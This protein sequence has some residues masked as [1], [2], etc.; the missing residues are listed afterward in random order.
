MNLRGFREGIRIGAVESMPSEDKITNF[1]IGKNL[2][3]KAKFDTFGGYRVPTVRPEVSIFAEQTAQ[4][5]ERTPFKKVGNN[6]YRYKSLSLQ[7]AKFT[8]RSGRLFPRIKYGSGSVY[9]FQMQK[10][11]YRLPGDIDE[12]ALISEMGLLNTLQEVRVAKFN[13]YSKF[14][15]A[16][17]RSRRVGL[18]IEGMNPRRN[19]IDLHAQGFGSSEAAPETFMGRSLWGETRRI[20]GEVYTILA[21]EGLRKS[22][23][24]FT[25]RRGDT[26]KIVFSPEAHRFKDVA[27]MWRYAEQARRNKGLSKEFGEGWREEFSKHFGEWKQYEKAPESKSSLQSSPAFRSP[28]LRMSFAHLNSFSMSPSRSASMSRSLSRRLSMSMSASM[29]R[30]M[31]RSLRPSLSPSRSPSPSR[32]FSR[33]MSRSMSRSLRPSL[34]PSRSP[35]PSRS[36]SLYMREET[37]REPPF[38]Y[39]IAGALFPGWSMEGYR[40]SRRKYSYAPELTSLEFGITSKKAP[41]TPKGGWSGLEIRPLVI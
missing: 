28:S 9:Q 24:V 15:L 11:I 21:E 4:L 40:P 38:S 8:G 39:V 37:P 30:S 36:F 20:K 19:K 32:S 5:F 22:S 35:S 18:L 26:G 6:F 3:Y 33:S 10:D 13:Q 34:S 25:L 17:G 7:E 23:S 1:L 12:Q 16:E 31:S 29:S 2:R 27:D 14:G 41:K